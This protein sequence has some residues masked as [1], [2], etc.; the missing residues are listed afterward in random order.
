MGNVRS[1]IQSG[2]SLRGQRTKQAGFI[3]LL[4]AN[5]TL[6]IGNL[7]AQVQRFPK[8]D[9]ES[10]YEY[11]DVQHPGAVSALR[12]YIDLGILA[13]LLM[14]ATWLVLKKR[15]RKGIFL[16][17]IFS[18]SY[19]GFFREGCVCSVGSLQN[20][21]QSLFLGSAIPWVVIAI[22]LLPILFSLFTGRIF[23]SGIC[24]LGAIQD[25]VAFFPQK[26]SKGLQRA[27]G[28]IPVVYLTLA[29]IYAITDTDF[30]I[31]RYDPFVGFFR[32]NASLNMVFFGLILLISGVFI[33]RPYCRFLCPYGV[34]L[35]W[36][37]F[38]SFNHLSITPSK[39][40]QCRLCE[41]SCPYDAIQYPTKEYQKVNSKR[42]VVAII[43][44]PI[45]MAL[46]GFGMQKMAPT[47]ASVNNTVK[48]A[49]ELR[50]AAI[51]PN[52]QESLEM[53]AFRVSGKS[54]AELFIEEKEVQINFKLYSLIGGLF[55]GLVFGLTLVSALY[56]AKRKD[57]VPDKANCLS[58]ARCFNDC[59][60]GKSIDVKTL[61]PIIK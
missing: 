18:V 48:L 11:P 31:C 10:G 54:N 1:E 39:C 41:D 25:L 9:F 44:I 51:D 56:N 24:P 8:P 43:L 26:L 30:I 7:S 36:V 57:Y 21:A 22:F 58:C 33:A 27:L 49:E 42:F 15:S 32:M 4:I 60:V 23:C 61:R 12:E 38:V 2:A 3:T 19:F 20:V 16:I 45:W 35:K 5:G 14:L 52:Y 53:E 40:V 59:P 37:S 29:V 50:I 47:L 55:I 46:F 28:L 17:S 34:I 13:G 6:L